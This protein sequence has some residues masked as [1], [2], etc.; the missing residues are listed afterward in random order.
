MQLSLNLDTEPTKLFALGA[1]AGLGFRVYGTKLIEAVQN[2]ADSLDAEPNTV[3]ELNWELSNRPHPIAKALCHWFN[4]FV[5]NAS[6]K[7]EESDLSLIIRH[8]LKND[9]SNIGA[10]T[11]R[12]TEVGP[13]LRNFSKEAK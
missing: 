5:E 7:S 11:P 10:N 13:F 9:K 6:N 3:H 1:N 12:L 2:W 8:Y 4:V